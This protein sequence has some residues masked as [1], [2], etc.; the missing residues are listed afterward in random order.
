MAQRKQTELNSLQHRRGHQRSR[1]VFLDKLKCVDASAVSPSAT[2]PLFE[3]ARRLGLSH[4]V[5]RTKKEKMV[6]NELMTQYLCTLR[7]EL[8]RGQKR[9]KPLLAQ[10]VSRVS[11]TPRLVIV[12]GNARVGVDSAWICGVWCSPLPSLMCAR[13]HVAKCSFPPGVMCG[14]HVCARCL[15]GARHIRAS[16]VCLNNV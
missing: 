6:E 10:T 11:D 2:F 14:I 9:R 3:S 7:Q 13:N 12:L 16:C 15:C 1:S 5:R 8:K 4:K